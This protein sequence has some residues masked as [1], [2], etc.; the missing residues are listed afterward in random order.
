VDRC[1]DPN[2]VR[3]INSMISKLLCFPRECNLLWI[4]LSDQKNTKTRSCGDRIRAGPELCD[5]GNSVNGDGCSS[6]CALE[7]GWTCTSTPCGLSTCSPVCGDG[8]VVGN[9]QC[10][11]G[12][13][14]AGCSSTCIEQ[15]GYE[16]SG[17]SASVADT[18]VT[19]SLPPSPSPSPSEKIN[20]V[21]VMYVYKQSKLV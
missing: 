19:R 5:D 17:G 6:T 11:A 13:G 8:R 20:N 12:P 15:C 2:S 9:E 21:Y 10:D 4:Q 3:G 18:C 7:P 1:I 14:V 16:C